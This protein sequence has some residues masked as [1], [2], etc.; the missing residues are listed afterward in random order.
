MKEIKADICI[1]GG[2][3]IGASLARELSQYNKKVIVLEADPRV[4]METSAGNSGLVHGGFDPTPGKLNAILN[5]QGKHRYEDW[6]R[7]LDFPYLRINSTVVGFNQ[8]EMA[9]IKELYNRG[10]KNGLQ[11]NELEIINASELQKREPRIN[12]AALGALVCNSSIAVD[13]VELTKTLFA[14]AIHNGVQL[15]VNSQVDKI[16]KSD[17]QYHIETTQG[18]RFSAPVII[19]AAGH[20]AD[21][22][23]AKAGYP[24]YTLTARRGQYRILDK[25]QVAGINSVLFMVPTIHGKGVIV[26]PMLN[27][28]LMVGPTAEDGI[29]K[30]ETSLITEANFKEIAEIGTKLIPD[31]NMDRTIMAY[32]GSRPIYAKT[33][34]FYIKPA[35]KDETFINV[36]GMKSPA[37]ASAPAIADYVIDKFIQPLF[38]NFAKNPNWQPVQ[39]NVLSMSS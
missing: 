30:D 19:N 9:A 22:L 29:A 21:T 35:L 26:A 20:Y 27:G 3:I 25:T 10:L 13:T 34:D 14:N 5:I 24:D 23:A 16:S 4:G 12:K 37:I 1:I 17:G 15:F 6:I 2:G 31:L 11:A 8:T 7:D 33:D 39:Q 28:H 36:A 32:S 18:N 38:K